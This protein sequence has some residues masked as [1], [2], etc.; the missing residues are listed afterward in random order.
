VLQIVSND[1][2]DHPEDSAEAMSARVAAGELAGPFLRDAEQSAA[3]AYGVTATPEVFLVDREGVVRY[4]GAPDADHDDPAQD[5]RWLRDALDD[6]LAGREV[7][8]PAS[9]PSGC[10]V[11]WRVELLWWEGCPTHHQAE[12]LLR[13]TLD[14]IGRAEVP[15]VRREVR[16]RDE[17]TRRGFVGSPTVTVGAVDLFPVDAAPA[18]TCRTYTL[19]DGRF[20]PLPDPD[21]LAVRLREALA[22]PWDLPGWTDP[23]RPA[24]S[25]A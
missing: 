23:R 13:E 2:T 24:R 25:D 22:R 9:P 15:V 4:H 20:S 5:A 19:P 18:L 6:V 12:D 7:A 8:R 16:S 17:A 3:R 21:D 1:E 10:S 14:G 11:K